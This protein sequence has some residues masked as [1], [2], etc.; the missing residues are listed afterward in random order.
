MA[1]PAQQPSHPIKNGDYCQCAGTARCELSS[2]TASQIGSVVGL[3]V[4]LLVFAF[5]MVLNVSDRAMRLLTVW[6][7]TIFVTS[8]LYYFLEG[9]MQEEQQFFKLRSLKRPWT[10]IEF[11]IRVLNVVVIGFAAVVPSMLSERFGIDRVGSGMYFMVLLYDLFLFWDWVV[12]E[13]GK[14]MD[15]D[16]PFVGDI[17]GAISTLIVLWFHKV[18]EVTTALA[19]IALVVIV[20]YQVGKSGIVEFLKTRI[21]RERLR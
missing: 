6:Y 2:L 17:L 16:V 18:S 12:C 20:V 9:W 13:G 1:T 14:R 7:F 8:S 10:N 15:K 11:V 5:Q 4:A 3:F 21:K 19:T